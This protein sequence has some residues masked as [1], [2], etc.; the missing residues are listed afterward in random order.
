M[1]ECKLI[2][3]ESCNPL[4]LKMLKTIIKREL[5][6]YKLNIFVTRVYLD[7]YLK[8]LVNNG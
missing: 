6:L 8:V 3:N 4:A 1:V 5:I 2:L 7:P